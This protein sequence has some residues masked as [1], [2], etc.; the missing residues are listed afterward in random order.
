MCVDTNKRE[1]TTELF[2]HK[3]PA[4]ICFAPIGINAIYHNEAELP[5]AK[6]A[7]ELGLPYCEYRT[8]R[9]YS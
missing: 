9:S 2:G 5:V 7:G 4:P 8:L 6:V 1:T 3:I